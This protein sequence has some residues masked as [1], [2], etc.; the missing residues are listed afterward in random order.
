MSGLFAAAFFAATLLP[1]SSEAVLAGILAS[2]KVSAGLA[3]GV[4]TLGNTLGSCMNW[5]IG[6]YAMHFRHRKW[7]P[8]NDAQITRYS[9]W[10]AKWG[11]WTLLAS[12]VP[13]IGDPLTLIS[14]MAKTPILVFISIVAVAK[15]LRYLA[16]AGL[17]QLVI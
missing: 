3:I 17:L 15:L 2:G 16:V 14:G 13:I 10:Y 8:A 1:G 4:A 5:G 6:R 11:V 9:N 7:F 12:W